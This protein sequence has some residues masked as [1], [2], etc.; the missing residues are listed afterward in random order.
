MFQYMLSRVAGNNALSRSRCTRGN[1]FMKRLQLVMA[2]VLVLMFN[3][4][5]HAVPYPYGEYTQLK[6]REISTR[7][8]KR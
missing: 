1:D 6:L 8:L 7:S 4:P 3:I 5:A 2:L